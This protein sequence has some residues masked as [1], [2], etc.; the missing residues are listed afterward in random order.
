LFLNDLKL[1]DFRNYSRESLTF[2]PNLNLLYGPNGVGKTNILEAIYYLATIRSHRSHRDSDLVRWNRSGFWLEGR[3][4]RKEGDYSLQVSY[5]HEAGKKTGINGVAQT[6]IGDFVGHLNA[7]FFSPEDLQ[8][9]KGSP[10][11]RRQFL[12]SELAQVNP[13]YRRLLPAYL[14]ILEQRNSLLKAVERASDS[15][16]EAWD[17]QLVD[18]GTRIIRYRVDA[19]RKLAALARLLHRRVTGGEEELELAYLTSVVGDG[20]QALRNGDLSGLEESFRLRL[21]AARRKELRRGY[22]LVGPHRDDLLITLNG[23]D[24]RAFAS[25][26]QQR[27]T[28]LSL[29]LAELEFMRAET[30]EYPVLLLDDVM[31]ELDQKRRGLL[32]NLLQGGLQTFITCTDLD[33]AAAGLAQ[34][35]RVFR[36]SGGN[37]CLEVVNGA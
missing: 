2:N 6:R 27:T 26:G 19:L 30:G 29:K 17:A 32:V 4:Y 36:V 1:Q 20:L 15:A 34:K 37:T 3:V 31:S 16:L 11:I 21:K 14:R 9:V 13:Y 8:L 18:Y 25:Q 33:H 35:A 24:A 5:G 22:T 23:T 7:V 28:V 10:S 12:D